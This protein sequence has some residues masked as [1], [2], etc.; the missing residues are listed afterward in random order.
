MSRAG[1]SG[2]ENGSR[3]RRRRGGGGREKMARTRHCY[4]AGGAVCAALLMA[5]GAAAQTGAADGSAS[6]AP[7]ADGEILVT[8]RKRAESLTDVPAAVTALTEADR[9]NLV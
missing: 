6:D 5:P 1:E 4:L 2:R 3:R 9:E 7:A 8:A